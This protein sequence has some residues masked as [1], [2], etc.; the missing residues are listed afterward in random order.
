VKKSAKVSK[1]GKLYAFYV[2]II[3]AFFRLANFTDNITTNVPAATCGMD[4]K[5]A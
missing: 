5:E 2:N 4:T 1:K 3:F